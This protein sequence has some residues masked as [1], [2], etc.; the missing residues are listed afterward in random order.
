MSLSGVGTTDKIIALEAKRIRG[1]PSDEGAF[2]SF[3]KTL[4]AVEQNVSAEIVSL[5]H[6]RS[7]SSPSDAQRSSTAKPSSRIDDTDVDAYFDE[8]ENRITG[9]EQDLLSLRHQISALI[10]CL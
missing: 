2:P 8:I 6:H 3:E 9:L 4:A 5:P 1:H 7:L 10:R